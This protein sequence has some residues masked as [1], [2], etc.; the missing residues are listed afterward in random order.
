MLLSRLSAGL[1]PDAYLLCIAKVKLALARESVSLTPPRNFIGQRDRYPVKVCQIQYGRGRLT[2]L[3]R[4]RLGLVDMGREPIRQENF[5]GFIG[6]VGE[7]DLINAEGR[8]NGR[9]CIA[10]PQFYLIA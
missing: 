9:P 6:A 4:W 8:T 1:T 10:K 7:Y 3:A 5:H 2:K